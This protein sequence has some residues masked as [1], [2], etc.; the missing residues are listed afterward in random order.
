M[1]GAA[2][3]F[4]GIFF[5][6]KKAK[7]QKRLIL[8]ARIVNWAFVSLPGVNLCSSD[9]MEHVEELSPAWH[10]ALESIELSLG[11]GD[12]QDCFHRYVSDDE[13]ASY[14]GVDTVLASE[15][16]LSG[17]YLE[18]SLLDDHSQVDLLWCYFPM[19]FS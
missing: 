18:G 16:S 15:L 10:S 9:A 5:V 4:L 6:N 1:K 2:K 8:D 14:F 11:L 7:R 13:F 3:H 19:G 17:C 12:I